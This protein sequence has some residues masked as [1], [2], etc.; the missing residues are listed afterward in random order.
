MIELQPIATAR[1][2]LRLHIIVDCARETDA[3][4]A[5]Y[6]WLRPPDSSARH[7]DASIRIS[8]WKK[9]RPQSSVLLLQITADCTRRTDALTDTFSISTIININFSHSILNFYNFY[10]YSKSINFDEKNALWIKKWFYFKIYR[11]PSVFNAWKWVAFQSEWPP[12]ADHSPLCRHHFILK[13]LNY[14]G[15]FH[16][17]SVKLTAAQGEHLVICIQKV[18]FFWF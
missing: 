18:Q 10:A 14:L 11:S 1:Q 12:R 17:S 8:F 16:E 9:N 5:Y 15:P 13:F 6:R 3:S 7:T 2:T 4:I